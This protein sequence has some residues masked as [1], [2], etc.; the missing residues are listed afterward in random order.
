MIFEEDTLVEVKFPLNREE[1]SGSREN[2]SWLPGVIITSCEDEYQILV[3][4][5]RLG[6]IEDGEMTYPLCFRDSTEIRELVN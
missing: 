2:W 4:D 6:V 3:E 5:E 1:E